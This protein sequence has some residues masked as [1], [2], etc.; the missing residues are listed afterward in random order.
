MIQISQQPRKN[1]NEFTHHIALK[2][3][4]VKYK[5]PLMDLSIDKL[6]I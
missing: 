3:F 1:H 4:W 2:G 5:K 6:V